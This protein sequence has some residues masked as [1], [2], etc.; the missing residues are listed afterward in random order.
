MQCGHNQ[1][2]IAE[3]SSLSRSVSFSYI[4]IL[5]DFVAHIRDISISFRA[6]SLRMSGFGACLGLEGGSEQLFVSRKTFLFVKRPGTTIK[7][8]LPYIYIERERERERERHIY[9]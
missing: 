7:R 1:A 5:Y 2:K 6:C 3:E 4:S 9:I 8:T